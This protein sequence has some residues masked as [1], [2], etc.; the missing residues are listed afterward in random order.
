M[1]HGADLLE[2]GREA[3]ARRDWPRARS[4]LLEVHA[5][6][7]L[8]PD[9]L[10]ML[11]DTA[12]WMGLIDESV[13]DAEQAYRAYLDG[14]AARRAATATVA[15]AVNLFLRG[16]EEIGAAWMSRAQRHLDGE[17]EGPEHGYILY[18]L[19][20]EG[21]PNDADTATVAASARRVQAIGRRHG[22]PNLVATGLLG[23]GR[24]LVR[25]GQVAR[26]MAL[27]DEAM[28]GVVA[29]EVAPD[30]AGNVYCHL[31]A[32]CW[33]LQDVRRATAWVAA[34]EDWLRGLPSAVVFRG[35]CRVH[36]GQLLHLQGEWDR[37]ESEAAAVARDVARIHVESA[38]EGHYAVGEIRRLRGD[39]AGAEAAYRHAHELGRDP[40][41]GLAL[42]RLA[43]GR[44]DAA[45]ASIA[46]ALAA[47]RAPLVRARLLAAQVE[48]MLEA[49]D[50][51]SAE[52]AARELSSVAATFGTSGLA[53][54][55]RT[56]D[57]SVRL[58]AGDA[59]S[60]IGALRDALGRWRDLGAPYEVARV[61]VRLGDAYRSLGDEDLAR[62]ELEAAA[63]AF[64]DLGA[65]ADLRR[66]G[67][68]AG[69]EPRPGGLSDREAEVLA[70]IATG[71]TNRE[72]AEHLV[73]SEKTVARH[74]SNVFDKLGVSSRTEAAAVAFA[75]GLTSARR[76]PRG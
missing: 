29:G 62:L 72:V 49:G 68:A 51:A 47:T 50:V 38:A 56:A 9:D 34:T 53:A 32:A 48:I 65:E 4:A 21:A 60:A 33:E 3:Y 30:W 11:S 31:M 20:V 44:V 67:T 10:L 37:A 14:G 28:V 17:P 69:V 5:A 27:L 54:C 6:G 19:D 71:M 41:P 45:A 61:R 66:L 42:L 25:S 16:D 15:I 23:E 35:V 64:G 22:D 52:G 73:L 36:R 18:L 40:Q 2:A 57:G 13:A 76:R 63:A 59:A 24:A 7:A 75:H 46:A 39:E 1:D 74:L 70:L 26:G 43:Q 8:D 55:A 12:W 58:A